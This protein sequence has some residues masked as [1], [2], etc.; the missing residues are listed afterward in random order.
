MGCS[1][2]QQ[3]CGERGCSFDNIL[4]KLQHTAP[5][6]TTKR[7]KDMKWPGINLKDGQNGRNSGAEHFAKIIRDL[8]ETAAF[9]AL[10]SGQVHVS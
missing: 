6:A 10:G 3:W 9:S 1:C 5:G 8:M 7:F 2:H 4:V